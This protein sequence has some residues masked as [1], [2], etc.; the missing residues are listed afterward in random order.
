M[1]L[2]LEKYGISKNRKQELVNFCRQYP[3]WVDELETGVRYRKVVNLPASMKQRHHVSDPTGNTAVRRVTLES[4]RNLIEQAA[5]TVDWDYCEK[6]IWFTCYRI[7]FEKLDADCDWHSFK[8]FI[9]LFYCV[10]D[11]MKG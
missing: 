3:E 6:I 9:V 7:P 11:E 2:N 10:L 4:K 8:R 5:A 1:K